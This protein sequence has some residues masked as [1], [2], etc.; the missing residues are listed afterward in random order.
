MLK[1]KWFTILREAD[2]VDGGGSPA[3]AAATPPAGTVLFPA[4]TP[5]AD[6]QAP[7]PAAGDWKEYVPDP[8]KSDADNA[9]A[10][11]EHD[12]SKPA[13]PADDQMAKVPED[14]KYDLKMPDGVD[15]DD[16]MVAALSPEFKEM[17]LTHAQAQK[18]VDKYTS[19]MQA[20]AAAQSE[21]FGKTVA[22]WADEAKADKEIGGDKWDGTVLVAQRAVNKLGT[23]ALKDFLNASGAGNHPEVIRFMAKAGALIAEDQPATGGA[24]GAGKPA[25][26]A[27]TLFPNDAPKG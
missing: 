26:A 1:N 27:Y 25:E 6:G 18:L 4:D 11:A 12:K 2:G 14:G 15:Q 23:P 9:A 3:A 22:G 5:P 7:A 10:K 13:A 21:T 16:E 19:I 8:A 17:G 20:R 24:G